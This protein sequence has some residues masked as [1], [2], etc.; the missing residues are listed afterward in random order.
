VRLYVERKMRTVIFTIIL[1]IFVLVFNFCVEDIPFC[2]S[3]NISRN[4]N[5]SLH[6]IIFRE[7]SG[8]LNLIWD[9]ATI[10]NNVI[11]FCR[12]TNNGVSWST[13]I[14]VSSIYKNSYY[15]TITADSAGNLNA[16]WRDGAITDKEIMYSRSVDN[17]V[18]WSVPTNISNNSTQSFN[19]TITVDSDH[20]LFLAWEDQL[21]DSTEILFSRSSDN[22]STWS[23][24]ANISRNSGLSVRPRIIVDKNDNLHLAWKDSNFGSGE[25]LYSHST[26]HGESWDLPKN[27]S[28]NADESRN[29][30]ITVDSSNNLNIAWQDGSSGYYEILFSRSTDNGVTWS[31]PITIT[32]SSGH[33]GFP[34]ITA[35]SAGNLYIAW[36]DSTGQTEILYSRSEDNG[37]TWSLPKNISNNA[38]LSMRPSII[39][40]A[41]FSLHVVWQDFIPMNYEIFYCSGH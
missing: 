16:A 6:P 2:T 23:L 25:I 10:G 15:P 3:V 41:L 34:N 35:D 27:I 36:E 17:G 5:D 7:S 30:T 19:P 1:V 26:N 33:S 14:N 18:T 32:N 20:N 12:S 38:T 37:A 40:D 13:P 8:T 31:V 9:N 4:D 21:P 22:G 28:N 24:P 11:M 39:V 29:L